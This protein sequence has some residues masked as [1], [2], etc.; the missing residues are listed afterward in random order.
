MKVIGY[1]DELSV[2]PDERVK[3]YVSCD[4][5]RYHADIVRLINGDTNP[6]GP[7]FKIE[8][9]RTDVDTA[10]PGRVQDTHAGSHV[11]VDDHPR[12]RAGGALT[13]QV[14]LWPTMPTK[15]PGY[16]RSG[17]QGLL[18]KW[19]AAREAGYGLFIG[20]DGSLEAW[21]G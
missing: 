17:P 6:A 12:M 2:L 4:T 20:E 3:F 14:L 9:V 19:D 18:T 16:W 21:I 10:F 11:I 8:P 1:S 7:G 15:P 13:L 5:E